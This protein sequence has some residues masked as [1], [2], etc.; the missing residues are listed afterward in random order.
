MK[1]EWSNP[2]A[3]YIIATLKEQ[4]LGIVCLWTPVDVLCPKP[5]Y[6]ELSFPQEN[7]SVN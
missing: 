4:Y 1:I 6:P 5:N 2:H 3:I 7:T